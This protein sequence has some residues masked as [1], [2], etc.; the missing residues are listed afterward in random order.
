MDIKKFSLLIVFKCIFKILNN[1][2]FNLIYLFNKYIKLN[3]KLFNI[4]KMLFDRFIIKQ[5]YMKYTNK[6]YKK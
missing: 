6:K 2:I 1:L 4:L 5:N 3:I